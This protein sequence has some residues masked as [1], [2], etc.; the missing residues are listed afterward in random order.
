ME[1][2]YLDKRKIVA[3]VLSYA[4]IFIASISLYSINPHGF[5]A[6]Y[7]VALFFACVFGYRL[8][9]YYELERHVYLC[10]NSIWCPVSNEYFVREGT[11]YRVAESI[12]SKDEMVVICLSSGKELG[13]I[14]KHK[15]I[16]HFFRSPLFP[17]G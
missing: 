10:T 8:Y 17:V 5:I 1:L 16:G 6:V 2:D 9:C 14:K 3:T 11:Y 12:D 13:T 15:I 7:S 4:V